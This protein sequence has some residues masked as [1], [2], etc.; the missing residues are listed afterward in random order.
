LKAIDILIYAVN[1]YEIFTAWGCFDGI[2]RERERV[3]FMMKIGFPACHITFEIAIRY[4][5][6]PPAQKTRLPI[7]SAYPGVTL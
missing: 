4:V 7:P 6:S 2:K 5:L 3:E 1:K